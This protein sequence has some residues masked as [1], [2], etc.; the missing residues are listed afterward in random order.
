M[1]YPGQTVM[2]NVLIMERQDVSAESNVDCELC[3]QA[4]PDIADVFLWE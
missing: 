1:D 2:S 3:D 4:W